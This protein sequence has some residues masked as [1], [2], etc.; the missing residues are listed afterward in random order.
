MFLASLFQTQNERRGTVKVKRSLLII[1]AA[2]SILTLCAVTANAEDGIPVGEDG[3]VPTDG[4]DGPQIIKIRV[5]NEARFLEIYWDRCVD[6]DAAV[7]PANFTLRAGGKTV[8][9]TPNTLDSD[10]WTDTIYFDR[11]NKTV[12]ASDAHCMNRL[13][14]SL[15]MSSI[16]FPE[17]E[18]SK[19]AS[20][21][22]TLEVKGDSIVDKAGKSAK[23]AVYAGVPR[24]DYYTQKVMTE[25]GI[26]IK[27]DDT[28]A[29]SSLELAAKQVE[30]ELSQPGT[31]IAETMKK[32]GCSLAV[33][34][35]RENVYMI[36][37]HRYGF[38]TSM[39]DLEG[40]GGNKWNGCV[41]SIAEVNI[42]RTRNSSEPYAN[43]M[44]PN[45][46]VLIH[47]FG[48]CI[49]SIGLEENDDQTLINEYFAAYENAVDTGLWPNTY[50]ISNSDEFFATMCA[51]W[52]NNMDDVSSWTDGTRSPLNTREEM[53]EYDPQTYAFFEK[54]LPADT[55]LPAPWNTHSPDNYHGGIVRPPIDNRIACSEDGVSCGVF[56][57]ETRARGTTWQVDRY[58]ADASRPQNDLCLWTPYGTDGNAS[59]MINGPWRVIVHDDGTV[60]LTSA[61]LNAAL[62]ATGKD[63]VAV[64]GRRY[65]EESEAQRWLFIEDTSTS[66]K[67]DGRLINI[68]YGTALSHDPRATDGAPLML[69]S[70]ADGALWMLRNT[71][72]TKG[73]KQAFLTPSAANTPAPDTADPVT[74]APTDKTTEPPAED[75]TGTDSASGGCGSSLGAAAV[76]PALAACVPLSKKRKK[77][78]S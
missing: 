35:S 16:S 50:A 66:N 8:S 17:S 15:H 24:L 43:T 21:E 47:E 45:E 2:L 51:I 42:T 63:T 20:G 76:I 19:L 77:K 69:T 31:G 55:P 54:I 40:Y 44:Y 26:T 23:S 71:S 53:K 25:S 36:P 65:D 4:Y 78:H 37:E 61:D 3:A 11:E 39:Y 62:T 57:L 59:S 14:P 18:L 64:S 68:K 27:G 1:L 73:E 74:D 75:S 41:S 13:D 9:L 72:E 46:N 48:H 10:G 70:E 58:A 7:D 28:V 67:F 56:K 34:S 12:A 52:F 29:L 22:L 5:L 38:R 49:K 33:Y 30:V 6:E 32:W 60:S